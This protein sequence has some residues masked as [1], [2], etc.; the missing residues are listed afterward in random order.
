[1]ASSADGPDAVIELSHLAWGEFVKGDPEPAEALFSQRDDVSLGNPFGTFV[2]GWEQAKQ[3]MERAAGLYR[4]GEL[5]P[6]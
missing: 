4:E 3:T 6:R 5:Q 1:M 2:R